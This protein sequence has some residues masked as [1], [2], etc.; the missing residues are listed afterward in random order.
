MCICIDMYDMYVASIFN[1]HG[2]DVEAE[3]RSM[4]AEEKEILVALEA[5]KKEEQELLGELAR[6]RQQEEQLLSEEEDFWTRVAEYQL[7]L[8]DMEEERAATS[9]SIRYAGALA[10]GFRSRAGDGRAQ[11]AAAQQRAERAAGGDHMLKVPG[12]VQHRAGSGAPGKAPSKA[13]GSY[14]L[15]HATESCSL[16][17]EARRHPDL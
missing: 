7:D 1:L 17:A 11:A 4:E 9:S 16:H 12:D 15:G 5:C 3:I 2:Q 13:D 8:H 14:K 6:Q 10:P